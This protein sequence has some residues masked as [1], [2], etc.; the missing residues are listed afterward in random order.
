[1]VQKMS[2][3]PYPYQIQFF[4]LIL[5]NTRNYKKLFSHKT[6]HFIKISISFDFLK[7]FSFFKY[8]NYHPLSS[9]IIEIH[10]EIKKKKKNYDE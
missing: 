5:T 8:N 10:K 1:M 6:L 9:F 3:T 2:F 4:F 7:N